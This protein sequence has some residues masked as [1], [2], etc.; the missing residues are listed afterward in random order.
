MLAEVS[1]AQPDLREINDV[2]AQIAADSAANLLSDLS[3]TKKRTVALLV[4]RGIDNGWDDATLADRIAQV[5]GLDA[6]Y[7][8]AVENQRLALLKA[9]VPKGRARDLSRDYAKRLRAH[10][11]MVIARNEV[12]RALCEAQRALWTHMQVSGDLSAYAVRVTVTHKDE[13]LC[14]VCRPQGGKRASLK[15]GT[16]G[17]PPFHPQCRCYE[18]LEDQGV[19]KMDVEKAITPGGRVGDDSPVG[20]PGGKQNWVDRAGGLPKY[21]R[22]VAHALMRAGKPKSKAIGMAVGI[23][24]NWAE[25]KGHVSPKVRAAAAKAIAEWEAKRA[26]SHVSKTDETTWNFDDY[27]EATE[28]LR[29]DGII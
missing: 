12:H 19:A 28:Q 23:V 18:V 16:G 27:Q 21:I 13:R 15:A 8:S 25:G 26:G 5:V 4:K 7:A 11:A 1:K 17:G 29:R 14:V 3:V 22:M 9:G 6:R 10:R 2:A 20:T 24:R